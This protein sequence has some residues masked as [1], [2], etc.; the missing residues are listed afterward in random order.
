MMNTTARCGAFLVAVALSTACG[1]DEWRLTAPTA[2][3]PP[4]P[5]TAGIPPAFPAVSRPA[6]VYVGPDSLYPWS[7]MHGSLRA[8]RYVLF[9][10][11]T[12]ELHFASVNYPFFAYRGTYTEENGVITFLWGENSILGSPWHATAAVTEDSLTVRY[13]RSMWGADFVDGVYVRTQ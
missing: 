4:P 9:D 13:N 7:A 12:F 8:T 6:R 3:T 5:A 2:S 11:H 10:D 1:T